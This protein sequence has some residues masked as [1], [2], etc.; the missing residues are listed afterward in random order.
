MNFKEGY[1]Y[2]ELNKQEM[3]YSQNLMF[4]PLFI[5]IEDEELHTKKREQLKEPFPL[6]RFKFQEFYLKR[7]LP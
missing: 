7:R 6:I 1:S 4:N 3:A 5:K 2:P